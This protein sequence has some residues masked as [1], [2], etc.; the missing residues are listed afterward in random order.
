MIS[1]QI[2]VVTSLD[3]T[4]KFPHIEISLN[5]SQE[6]VIAHVREAGA[7]PITVALNSPALFGTG[8]A[9]AEAKLG[10]IILSILENWHGNQFSDVS[11]RESHEELELDDHFIIQELISKSREQKTN[12]YV[13]TITLLL[14][15]KEGQDKYAAMLSTWPSLKQIFETFPN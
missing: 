11:G 1:D 13:G 14:K 7:Q 15:G 6:V 4:M 12:A 10:K 3:Q 8:P 2:N 5:D 9:A